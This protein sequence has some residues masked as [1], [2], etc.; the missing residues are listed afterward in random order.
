MEEAVR[1]N[2]VTGFFDSVYWSRRFRRA[3]EAKHAGRM[4]AVPQFEVPQIFVEVDDD[5]DPS[6]TSTVRE[7]MLSTHGSP[8]LSPTSIYESEGTMRATGIDASSSSHSTANNNTTMNPRHRANSIQV[9]PIHSPTLTPQY[10]H[11]HHG[12]SHS[13]AGSDVSGTG[14][15]QLSSALSAPSSPHGS[16][17]PD[18]DRRQ[19]SAVSAQDV[20]DVLDNSAWGESIRRSFTMRRSG[21]LGRRSTNFGRPQ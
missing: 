12:R 2:T 11:S 6:G 9:S 16:P 3:M 15:W 20:M 21:T 17:R 1:R 4:T 18:D 7:G 5:D 14:D 19:E 10:H 8:P 13:R